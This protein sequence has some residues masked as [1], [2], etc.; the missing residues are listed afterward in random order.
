MISLIALRLGIG[1]HFFKE[2]AKKFQ[3]D[4]FTS[5]Y[6][7]QTA[8]GPFA[9][10]YK[11]MI[12]DRQ[13]RERLDQKKTED[14]W[15]QYKDQVARHF[16]FDE[17][18]L[19]KADAELKRSKAR[20]EAF[21]E[22]NRPDIEEYLL[23][24][25]RLEK[26]KADKMKDVAFQRSWI[27]SKE[28]ELTGKVRPWLSSLDLMG[29]QLQ[30][31]LRQ[32]ATE[33]QRGRGDCPIPDRSAML[34]DTVVKYVV[35]GV[36]VLLIL[37]L[38]TRF[39]ALM[40]MGFL[41]SVMSTQ[42]PWAADANTDYFYYQLVEILAMLVLVAFAAGRFAGLDYLIYGLRMRCCPPKSIEL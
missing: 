19:E 21:H 42:P 23:E 34:V 28:A 41:L 14:F 5:V 27:A 15:R 18:Q 35:I 1:W 32:I 33:G 29:V 31:N 16:D 10:F 11:S 3:G 9:D 7:L 24:C 13:G 40:G 39:A 37:G 4:S 25:D 6:F 36:G 20:L 8:K 17:K 26:A 38:F 12:P 22:L 30:D 2:G